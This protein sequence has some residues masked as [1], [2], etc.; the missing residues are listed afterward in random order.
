MG[1]DEREVSQGFIGD[2]GHVNTH[3]E[4]PPQYNARV[5]VLGDQEL[6]LSSHSI[7]IQRAENGFA[8]KV[9]CK[10]FVFEKQDHLFYALSLY[11]KD[12]K[13]AYKEYVRK[14]KNG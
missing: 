11:Y 13:A 9:G 4:Q 7:I 8:V 12:P 1:V 14:D 10:D 2:L 6:N 5:A 3:P